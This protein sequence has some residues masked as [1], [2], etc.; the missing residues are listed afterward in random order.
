MKD[1]LKNGILTLILG[2]LALD[3]YGSHMEVPGKVIPGVQ[4]YRASSRVP[5]KNMR[6][7]GIEFARMAMDPF[8][9]RSNQCK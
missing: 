5:A 1:L 6:K 8:P 7:V 9:F 2:I 3:A 4:Q